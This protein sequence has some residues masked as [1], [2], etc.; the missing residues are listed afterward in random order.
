[1]S[2]STQ[3]STTP[4]SSPTEAKPLQD[5]GGMGPHSRTGKPIPQPDGGMGPHS[6]TETINPQPDGGMG[7]H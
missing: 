5:K 2:E 3:T 7:P 6:S 1:M 4:Q